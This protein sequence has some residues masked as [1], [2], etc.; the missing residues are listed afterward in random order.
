MTVVTP[1]DPIELASLASAGPSTDD[2]DFETFFAVE[3]VELVSL[4]V[5]LSGDLQAAEDIAQEALSR[6]HENW[7]RVHLLD[8]PG[9]WTRRVA[10][11]LLRSRGRRGAAERRAL[12][13][14]MGRRRPATLDFT[15]D[16]GEFWRM[17]RTLPGRQAEAVTL[18]Y[19]HDLSIADMATAMDCAEGTAKAHLHRA[20][21]ALA[22]HLS[23]DPT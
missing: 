21:S 23:E 4:G 5:A 17:V 6:A 3:F 2:L 14:L 16:T 22:A 1:D 8:K 15:P 11:N 19:L 9:A 20:R 7:E 18:H 10:I 13:R 12:G